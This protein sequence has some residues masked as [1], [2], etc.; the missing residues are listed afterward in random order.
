MPDAASKTGLASARPPRDPAEELGR[1]TG[2]DAVEL[3]RA[4]AALGA[5]LV[6]EIVEIVVEIVGARSGLRLRVIRAAGLVLRR[7]AVAR[8]RHAAGSG[9]PWTVRADSG[10]RAQF[11]Q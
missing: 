10:R 2:H 5:E 7:S 3:R 1:D 4:L 8:A 6:V 9:R 11:A